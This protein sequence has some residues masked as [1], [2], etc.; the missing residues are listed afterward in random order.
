MNRKNPAREPLRPASE[1]RRPPSPPPP[2]G[3]DPSWSTREPPGPI[4]AAVYHLLA[5]FVFVVAASFLML[6]AFDRWDLALDATRVVAFFFGLLL[7]L[8][9]GLNGLAGTLRM[10]EAYRNAKRD[11]DE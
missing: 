3:D 4:L 7:C 10:G 5:S 2:T 6:W 9:A 1:S 11:P 8:G